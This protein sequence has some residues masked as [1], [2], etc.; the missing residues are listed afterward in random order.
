MRGSRVSDTAA[1][2][3]R[4]FEAT[5]A[6]QAG[7]DQSRRASPP[8]SFLSYARHGLGRG[9]FLR[10]S[11]TLSSGSTHALLSEQFQKGERI[12]VR[13]SEGVAGG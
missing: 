4:G 2:G 12:E 9:P 8:C 13:R 7:A 3:S 11:R 1:R 5:E 6:G 10:R